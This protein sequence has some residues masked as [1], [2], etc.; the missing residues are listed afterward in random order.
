MTK[1]RCQRCRSELPDDAVRVEQ[2]MAQCPACGLVFDV[3]DQLAVPRARPSDS[4][5]GDRPPLARARHYL[6]RPSR[7]E[8]EA[9]PT[10]VA[11]VARYRD[12]AVGRTSGRASIRWRWWFGRTW[13]AAFGLAFALAL[14]A[15][16]AFVW[17]QGL[18]RAHGAPLV[19]GLLLVGFLALLGSILGWVI[20]A[21]I[22]NTTTVSIADGE[23]RI[24]SGP[25]PFGGNH[26]LPADEIVQLWTEPFEYTVHH[27][28]HPPS[29]QTGW[30]LE[31]ELSNGGKVTLMR[32]HDDPEELLYI[33]Q[34]IERALGIVDVPVEGEVPRVD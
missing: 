8:V 20:L 5:G 31:V 21:G 12:G 9:H 1:V 6:R 24:H 13:D 30:K 27:K 10:G 33:E 19:A 16:S 4:P 34:V 32:R 29:K 25:I 7:F 15:A 28:R 2:M 18:R 11:A 22:A 26:T 14:L 17:A 23:L 3:S